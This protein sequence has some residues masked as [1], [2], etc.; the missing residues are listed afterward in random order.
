MVFVQ[1]FVSSFFILL[2]IGMYSYF[3][4]TQN[5]TKSVEEWALNYFMLSLTNNLYYLINV[6]SF[7]LSTL[8]SRL[9]RETLL[10]G[11]LKMLPRYLY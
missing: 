2:W 3:L 9:F 4:A 11:V 7:Y 8:T 5:V 1:V 6:R 10:T